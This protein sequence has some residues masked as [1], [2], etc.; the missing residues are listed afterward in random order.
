[1][2]STIL[3]ADI[4][5][6]AAEIKPDH[7][8]PA[9]LTQGMQ[10]H[11][12]Q[13]TRAYQGE[14]TDVQQSSRRINPDSRY[15]LWATVVMI[16]VL[17]LTSFMVSFNGLHDVAAW[18]GLPPWMRWAVPIF[19]D[20][21]ILAYS[22]AAVI[23]RSRGETVWPTWLT[24]AVFTA[25]SVV[26]NAAHALAAGEGQTQVQAWIGAVIAA[27][28]PV[29]VFAATEQLS[30]LAFSLPQNRQ[31]SRRGSRVA[32]PEVSASTAGPVEVLP[33]AAGS[34]S[35]PAAEPEAPAAEVPEPESASAA[36]HDE[37]ASTGSVEDLADWVEAQRAHGVEV[38]GSM[39]GRFLGKSERTGRARL[40]ALRQDR[41][42]L[43]GEEV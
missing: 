3:D 23:H 12:H 13:S 41:P 31:R 8:T 35:A 37:R 24:L 4:K 14:V 33:E 16:G 30:R 32:G 19:I 39:A 7:A 20:I 10:F 28:A 22:L 18:V 9:R 1:M 38:S 25:V 34:D 40:N 36:T 42:E 27:M 21:A 11:Q 43:F 6:G 29:A 5:T 15:T 26:A 2:T 17:G